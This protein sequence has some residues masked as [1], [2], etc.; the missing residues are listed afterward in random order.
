MQRLEIELLIGFRR[1]APRRGALHGFSN[2]LRISKVILMGLPEMPGAAFAST[3]VWQKR[4]LS[5]DVPPARAAASG[6]VI[7]FLHNATEA[8]LR[9]NSCRVSEEPE[10]SRLRRRHLSPRWPRSQR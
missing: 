3:E 10:P 4:T 7:G 2:G 8:A 6:A 1:Y 9:A 5:P